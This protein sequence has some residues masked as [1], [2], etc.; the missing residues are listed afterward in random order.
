MKVYSSYN[1]QGRLQQCREIMGGHGYSR[2][3]LIG[4]LRNNNDINITW[5][6]ENTVLIQQTEKFIMDHFKKKM[7]G[8]KIGD[9]YKVKI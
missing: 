3:N 4:N 5:E 9:K 7:N 2:F 6:G 8:E 1:A